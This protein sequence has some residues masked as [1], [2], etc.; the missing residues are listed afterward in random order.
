MYQLYSNY[1]YI[2]FQ[3]ILKEVVG[4]VKIVYFSI[5]T[6]VQTSKHLGSAETDNNE[7]SIIVT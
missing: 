3:K 2:Q 5:K 6:F 7:S 4:I 1:I